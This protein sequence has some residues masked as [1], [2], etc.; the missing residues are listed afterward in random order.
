MLI[1]MQI[2][3]YSADFAVK[4]QHKIRSDSGHKFQEGGH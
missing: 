2:A 1:E 4:F 3:A